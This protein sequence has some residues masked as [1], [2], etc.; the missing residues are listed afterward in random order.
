MPFEVVDPVDVVCVDDAR[1]C[2]SA[3]ELCEEIDGEAAPGELAE[4]A[5]TEGYGRVDETRRSRLLC[6][7]R[8]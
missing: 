2:E 7:F 4:E 6:R 1:G 8:A 3:E 5:E